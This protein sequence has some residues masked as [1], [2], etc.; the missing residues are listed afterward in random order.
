VVNFAVPVGL[1]WNEQSAGSAVTVTRIV[2]PAPWPAPGWPSSV[3][4][5]N[6]REVGDAASSRP[7]RMIGLRPILSDSAPK[8]TKKPV[9]RISDHG[10]HDVGR[11]K[12]ST[13]STFCRKNSA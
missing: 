4:A 5:L 13:L 7:A 1:N 9:P 2:L 11:L 12:L 3:S 10:D 8:N 6:S